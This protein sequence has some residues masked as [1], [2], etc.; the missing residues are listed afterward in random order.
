MTGCDETAS[1]CARG[2]LLWITGRISSQEGVEASGCPEKRWSPGCW[3]YLGDAWTWH[4]GTQLR[5]GTR[6]VRQMVGLGDLEGL[7]QHW[8]LYAILSTATHRTN[9][10][11]EGLEVLHTLRW[12]HLALTWGPWAP[13]TPNHEAA[14]ITPALTTTQDLH[15]STFQTDHAVC[16]SKTAITCTDCVASLALVSRSPWQHG[17]VCTYADLPKYF[18]IKYSRKHRS[19]AYINPTR[20]FNLTWHLCEQ[21]KLTQQHLCHSKILEIW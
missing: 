7:F 12:T 11:Q 17:K 18:L 3:R 9:S 16:H 14:Q 15:P 20:A 10:W 1:S 2:S 8:W 13:R 19:Q 5:D 21:F 4:W 6:E